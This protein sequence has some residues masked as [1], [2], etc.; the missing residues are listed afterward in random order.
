M[1][2]PNPE[3]IARI[4]MNSSLVMKA[5]SHAMAQDL[6]VAPV[7]IATESPGMGVRHLLQGIAG[8]LDIPVRSFAAGGMIAADFGLAHVLHEGKLVEKRR[9]L[10]ALD[11]V[12]SSPFG[13]IVLIDADGDADMAVTRALMDDVRESA[14][15]PTIV[16]I[17]CEYSLEDQALDA[18]Q[19][20]LGLHGAHV[21]TAILSADL[22]KPVPSQP[23]LLSGHLTLE[24]S[25]CGERY[26]E[27]ETT[28]EIPM[29]VRFDVFGR[30]DQDDDSLNAELDHAFDR[31]ERFVRLT[32]VDGSTRCRP[33]DISA[34]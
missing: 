32:I 13:S 10:E 31:G 26:F 25:K 3:R 7:L 5:V 21:P 34:I 8:A 1:P 29:I 14:V 11:S 2:T 6:A 22:S 30:E 15:G 4:H 24:G 23:V 18:I 28:S 9:T 16:V 17:A 27:I 19:A 20:S 12:T 33:Q